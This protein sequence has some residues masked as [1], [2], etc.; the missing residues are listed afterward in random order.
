MT[1]KVFDARRMVAPTLGLFASTGTLVCC[2]L[3]ALLVSAGAGATL[4]GLVSAAPWL[5]ALSKYKVWTFAISGLLI[6][7]AGVSLWQARRLPCPA[8]P[9]QALACARLRR[10]SAWIY[11]LS[12]AVWLTGFFFAF[13]AVAIF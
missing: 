1:G 7:F 2:A 3:P 5:I 13:V 8:D 12:L 11:G 10:V 9:R 6:A 4:A